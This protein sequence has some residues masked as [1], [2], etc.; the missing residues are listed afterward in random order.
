MSQP[1]EAL[2][3]DEPTWLAHLRNQWD[4]RLAK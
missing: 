1:A 2:L 4:D 3:D